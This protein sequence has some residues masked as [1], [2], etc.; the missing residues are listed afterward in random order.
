MLKNVSWTYLIRLSEDRSTEIDAVAGEEDLMKQTS[1][2]PHRQESYR[3]G[4][5][6]AEQTGPKGNAGNKVG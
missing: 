2:Y 1:N 6:Q 4:D 5:R 3:S